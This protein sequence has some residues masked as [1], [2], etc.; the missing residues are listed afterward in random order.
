MNCRRCILFEGL[1]AVAVLHSSAVHGLC[2]AFCTTIALIKELVSC[3]RIAAKSSVLTSGAAA[4]VI[5][6]VAIVVVLGHVK[7]VEDVPCRTYSAASWIASSM[8]GLFG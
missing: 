1:P 7:S 2:V 3:L 4:A 6:V 5:E 8:Y